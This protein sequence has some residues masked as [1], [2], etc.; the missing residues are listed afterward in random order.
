MKSTPQSLNSCAKFCTLE[1]AP[2]CGSDGR[3]YSNE[4]LLDVENCKAGVRGDAAITKAHDKACEDVTDS[5]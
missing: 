2:L 3:T 4:C 1:F 5:Q